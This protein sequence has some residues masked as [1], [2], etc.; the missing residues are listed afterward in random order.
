MTEIEAKEELSVSNIR[1]VVEGI[2]GY[3]PERRVTNHDLAKV[4]DTSDEW[5]Q[6][7]SGIVARHYVAEGE[8]SS[9]MAEAAAKVAMERAK[10]TPDDIDMVIVGTVTPDYTL[11]ATSAILQ[12]KLGIRHGMAMDLS[13]ACS[14]FIYGL[15]IANSYIVNGQ[16]KKALVVGVEK[17][18]SIL[19]RADRAAAILFGDG[20]GAAIVGVGEDTGSIADR[21]IHT[22]YLRCDG[23][24]KDYLIGTG[25]VGTTQE[26]G[27]ITMN[28]REVFRHAVANICE[29]SQKALDDAGITL[30][31]V[32]WFVPHQ[33]NK[34]IL[35]SVAS[36]LK[37]PEEKV[38][39]TVQDHGNTS[40]ASVPLALNVGIEDGRI[41]KGDLVLGAAMGAG[42]AWGSALFRM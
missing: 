32:D 40:A 10:C 8:L 21:G 29:A 39:V 26:V 16:S 15:S 41:K 1:A 28:G 38:I 14:G 2:G 17:I 7:R 6:E 42:F 30:D 19:H 24:T 37:I 23:H 35:D 22:T 34:R 25:G 9:D 12:D 11:P 27:N 5:I 36:R 20:A 4:M 3:L 33:A 18:S 31:D 13:A